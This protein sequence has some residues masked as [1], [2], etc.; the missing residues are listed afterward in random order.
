MLNMA[1]FI[2]LCLVSILLLSNKGGRNQPATGAPFE[3][4]EKCAVC[5]SGGNNFNP[6]AD[7]NFLDSLGNS[8]TI[9]NAGEK[10]TASLK[11]TSPGNVKSYG[12]QMVA[13]NTPDFTNAGKWSDLG[14]SVRELE[15]VG[16]DYTMQWT[17]RADGIFTMKWTAPNAG[18][19][20]FYVSGVAAN[21]NEGTS[22][23]K[24]FN[25]VFNYD[26]QIESSVITLQEEDLYVYPNPAQER[27]YVSKQF[28]SVSILNMNGQ[29]ILNAK[30]S[31]NFIN[32]EHL[33]NGAYMV[34]LKDA[35]SSFV[36]SFIKI[37]G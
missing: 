19:V 25:T 27:L 23:D 30:I 33:E 5:H 22:G 35:E 32:I 28:E 31:E 15:M 9:F 6:M 4:T 21:G 37:K 3:T 36:R 14:P 17:P 26:V 10:Y 1:R 18:S 29:T 7:L 8:A 13:V 12:F 34:I 16:R 20:S 11:I 2:V 24:A